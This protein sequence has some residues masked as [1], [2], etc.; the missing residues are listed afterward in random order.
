M[1][2]YIHVPGDWTGEQAWAVLEFLYH[3]EERVWDAHEEKLLKIIGPD[4]EP[5]CNDDAHE[6]PLL[7]DDD[8]PF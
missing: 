7:D 3:L 2:K 4:P 5:P 8:I 6:Q 1:L